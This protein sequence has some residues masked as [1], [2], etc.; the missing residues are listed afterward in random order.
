MLRCD[1]T[2]VTW[3]I[4]LVEEGEQKATTRK[5]KGEKWIA[6]AATERNK[7]TTT[8]K[9]EPARKR[10]ILS[11]VQPK[12][13]YRR[14]LYSLYTTHNTQ[15]TVSETVFYA[16]RRKNKESAIRTWAAVAVDAPFSSALYRRKLP[17]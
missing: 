5:K 1:V 10:F 8:T 12:S 15:H 13:L 11:A 2:I 4:Q 7:K 16:Q 9:K 6:A 3:V 17:D 14:E